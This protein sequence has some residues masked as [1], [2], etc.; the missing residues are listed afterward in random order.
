MDVIAGTAFGIEINS[1]E[2]GENAFVVNARKMFDSF[3]GFSIRL[4]LFRE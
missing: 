3:G 1:S 2:D 4:F